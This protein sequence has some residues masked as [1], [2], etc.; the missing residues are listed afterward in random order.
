MIYDGRPVVDQSDA[1]QVLAEL[2]TGYRSVRSAA[3]SILEGKTGPCDPEVLKGLNNVMSTI[4][5]TQQGIMM[6]VMTL[7]PTEYTTGKG[8]ANGRK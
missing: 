8:K 7:A 2:E 1:I 6:R 5:K 4:Q 3:G